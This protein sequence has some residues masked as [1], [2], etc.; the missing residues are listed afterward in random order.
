MAKYI[1]N[2]ITSS[3]SGAFG[4]EFVFRQVN[5]KTILT[6][7][8]QRKAAW[9]EK[10]IA[11]RQKFSNASLY[12]KAAV[13]NPG[14]KE[15]YT[16]IAKI[17][18]FRGGAMVAAMTDFLTSTQLSVAYAH[19]FDQNIGFPVTIV[20]KDNFKGKEM[21]VSISNKDGTITESGKAS[22]TFGDTAWS[23][24]TTMPYESIE[25]LKV[26]VTV[27]DRVGRVSRFE[28]GLNQV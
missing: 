4:R 1:R 7:L 14:M 8:P 3:I 28:K 17:K 2:A 12:A 21:T 15:E 19:Q 25:G 26:V 9:S 5:G 18:N 11:R 22:F 6:P 27:K 24:V 10:Q 23:Y 13:A 16:A 20:L